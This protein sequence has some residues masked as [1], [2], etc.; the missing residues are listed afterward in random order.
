MDALGATCDGDES[1]GG[2]GAGGG[3]ELGSHV[4]GIGRRGCAK[5]GPTLAE[6]GGG[7][8]RAGGGGRVG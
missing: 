6:G 2:V 3:L 8:Q 5:A 4:D 7:R 1:V